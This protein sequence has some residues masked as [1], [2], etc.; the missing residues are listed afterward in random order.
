VCRQWLGFEPAVLPSLGNFPDYAQP[1]PD[2][3]EVGLYV[4]H[5]ATLSRQCTVQGQPAPPLTPVT[6]P[7]TLLLHTPNVQRP[8]SAGVR[9]NT[10]VT[11]AGNSSQCQVTSLQSAQ[12]VER[13]WASCR[14][15]QTLTY[16]A[17]NRTSHT[18]ARMQP[19]ERTTPGQDVTQHCTRM[20]H[21]MQQQD[22]CCIC[23]LQQRAVKA[24]AGSDTRTHY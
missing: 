21:M 11:I 13:A 22:A 24:K 1:V 4:V 7:K 12:H 15:S 3:L 17:A 10:H 9:G 2:P 6:L 5:I 8:G 19:T 14:T 16:N 18:L 23:M 20:L